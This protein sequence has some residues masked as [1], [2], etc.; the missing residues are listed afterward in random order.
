M[1]PITL[2]YFHDPMCS[3]CWGFS[4][5]LRELRLGLMA[6]IAFTRILGGLAADNSATMP[7]ELQ[8]QI[9]NGWRRIESMIPGIK[10]NFDYWAHCQPRR[11][12]Y[13]ACRAV[14]AARRQGEQYDEIMTKAIQTAY[15][16][17]ARNPSLDSTLIDIAG[18][19]GLDQERFAVDLNSD[20]VNISLQKE[21][22]FS[23]NLDVDSF[24]SLILMID[25]KAIPIG[26]DYLN[27][28]T[29]LTMIS[30]HIEKHAT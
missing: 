20:T 26:I 28:E 12:T 10:F 15:Y 24:P 19:Q 2:Y 17:Q 9:Q 27:A 13:A 22:E 30:R 21:I 3:W 4:N 18:E 7:I 23:R 5:A 29:M 14:I 6:N 8:H 16:Q 11:S 25:D 1:K